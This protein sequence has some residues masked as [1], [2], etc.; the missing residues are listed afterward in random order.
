MKCLYT[1]IIVDQMIE[2][3]VNRVLE[4]TGGLSPARREPLLRIFLLDFNTEIV[5]Q[6]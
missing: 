6:C 1:Y 2:L 5:V 4:G 3:H